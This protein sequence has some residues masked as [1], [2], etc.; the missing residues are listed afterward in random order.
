[1]I[2][3]VLIDDEQH[4][5]DSL[6]TDLTKNCSNVNIVGTCNSAKEGILLIKKLPWWEI[7]EQIDAWNIFDSDDNRPAS[8]FWLDSTKINYG[9]DNLHFNTRSLP[10]HLEILSP[11]FRLFTTA[12]VRIKH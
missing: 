11:L 9:R 7:N 12:I 8:S 2:N 3:S 6:V 5:I 4:S 10:P 1:M